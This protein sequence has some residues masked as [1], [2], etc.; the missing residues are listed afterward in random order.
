MRTA[1][2]A[3]YL[4]SSVPSGWVVWLPL[5]PGSTKYTG[6]PSHPPGP[7]PAA[8]PA[9]RIAG[10]DLAAA[11]QQ[12]DDEHC[13]RARELPGVGPITAGALTATLGDAKVLKNGRQFPRG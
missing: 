2:G 12:R 4:R 6:S 7:C 5:M 13:R 8:P 10:C 3:S 11:A 9:C 1:L